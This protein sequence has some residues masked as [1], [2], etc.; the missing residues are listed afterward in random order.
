MSALKKDRVLVQLYHAWEQ[1]ERNCTIAFWTNAGFATSALPLWKACAKGETPS[2]TF[3]KNLSRHLDTTIQDTSSFLQALT[4]PVHP[5]PRRNEITDVAIRRTAE[6]LIRYR[7]DGRVFAEQVYDQ[8]QQRIAKAGTDL[9]DHEIPQHAALGATLAAIASKRSDIR[10]AQRYISAHQMMTELLWVHDKCS[11]ITISDINVPWVPDPHFTGR[12]GCLSELQE[13]LSPGNP[14]EV[15]PVVVCGIP[16][17][18]KTSLATQFAALNRAILRPIFINA[19]SRAAL[20]HDLAA[21]M[22]QGTPD[23]WQTGVAENRG[24]VT[25]RL[26]WTSATLLIIDGVTTTETIRGIIPRKALCRIIITSTLAHVDQGYRHLELLEWTRAESDQFIRTVLP[27]APEAD[28]STL[29]KRLFNHP[30][31]ITQAVNYIHATRRSID[32]YLHKLS[33]A[34]AEVLSCGEASGHLDSVVRSIQLNI[35]LAQEREPAA[36]D[37]LRILAHLGNT[38]VELALL[39]REKILAF[40]TPPEAESVKPHLRLFRGISAVRG[41]ERRRSFQYSP[42]K[43]AETIRETLQTESARDRAIETLITTS[44]ARCLGQSLSIHPLIAL[45]VRNLTDDP[46]PWLE[47]AFGIFTSD[48]ATAGAA[49]YSNLDPNLDH[50]ISLVISAI[51]QGLTGPAVISTCHAL[52]WRLPVIGASDAKWGERWTA[53][54]FGRK[55]LAL[56]EEGTS[57]GWLALGHAIDARRALA[58]A[59]CASGKFD[60][61]LNYLTR[62]I[63][64][65]S[66]LNERRVMFDTVLDLAHV[67]SG[68]PDLAHAH[69]ALEQLDRLRGIE[70]LTP[71]R[72]IRMAA[73]RAQLLRRIGRITDAQEAIR[74][75]MDTARKERRTSPGILEHVYN[76]AALIARDTGS[77]STILEY[78]L[79]ALEIRRER[80]GDQPDSEFI[81]ALLGAA[82]GAI[83]ANNFSLAGTILDEADSLTIEKFGAESI[84][85]GRVLSVRGRLRFV[86]R[87]YRKALIDLRKACRVLRSGTA[88]DHQELASPLVHLAQAACF[89]G[90]YREAMDSIREAYEIDLQRFGPDHPETRVDA[91]VKSSL[92]ALAIRDGWMGGDLWTEIFRSA[93]ANNAIAA[94]RKISPCLSDARSLSLGSQCL[95]LSCLGQKARELPQSTLLLSLFHP[96]YASR[97]CGTWVALAS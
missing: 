22:D 6:L 33:K 54:E 38:P 91:E 76:V 32:D 28:R 1:A 53:V 24:P 9:P 27:D 60:E 18:G 5:L 51:D 87:E 68:A 67:A 45:V 37:I 55:A 75:A 96:G 71:N 79:A 52:A 36:I 3:I 49:E 93:A 77:R 12:E 34:P 83:E 42:S 21:L 4:I 61:S 40:V 11:S 81:R 65:L 69:D 29:A 59:L 92:E 39:D 85:Y 23:M 19:S 16:G 25:P 94:E 30:L 35:E 48:I 66:Q 95:Y 13:M 90:Y 15:E 8:L 7:P 63:Q 31:A 89:L 26:P 58:Q 88:F 56:A 10:L 17:C 46:I 62:N 44:L 64:L 82:D 47:V 78:E 80:Y 84:M 97:N 72:K 43:R 73:M 74:Q 2:L 14:V 70:G 57:Q 50:L 86:R 20:I 41:A